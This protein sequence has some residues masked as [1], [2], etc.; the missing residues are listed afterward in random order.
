M[1]ESQN[2]TTELS[3]IALHYSVQTL[4]Y[5]V[6]F[7]ALLVML[8][9]F[10][11]PGVAERFYTDAGNDEM[12]FLHMS[13]AT[14]RDGGED[15]GRLVRTV[16]AALKLYGENEEYSD[17]AEK[18]LVMLLG[19]PG[20]EERFKMIDSYNLIA[21]PSPYFHPNLYS[22][23]D[24]YVT[25]LYK[26]GLNNGKTDLVLNGESL[27]V[28]Q[29]TTGTYPFDDGYFTALN[30]LTEYVVF[31]S[32]N[33]ETLSFDGEKLRELYYAALSSVLQEFNLSSPTLKSLFALKS[34]YAFS[35]AAG[36]TGYELGAIDGSDYGGC[37]TVGQ[38]YEKALLNYSIA[39]K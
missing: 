26:I 28:L 5:V 31:A 33:G 27:S 16:N 38:L 21:S 13:R 23:K 35:E 32:S 9:F 22:V 10:I 30:Q 8:L 4:K 18:Y 19:K 12:A 29:F 17:C 39:Q 37:S 2:R 1:S 6:I 20:I 24:Y 15:T 36:N 34:L 25:E 7:G 11:F 3:R 14:D